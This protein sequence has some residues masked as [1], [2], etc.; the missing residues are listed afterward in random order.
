M[1]RVVFFLIA[2]VAV[3]L[4]IIYCKSIRSIVVVILFAEPDQGAA[5]L[6]TRGTFAA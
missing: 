4:I 6:G 2:V 1:N 3:I 5:R